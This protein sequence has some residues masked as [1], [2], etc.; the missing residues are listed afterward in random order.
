M[1]NDPSYTDQ[2]IFEGKVVIKDL[3]CGYWS[4]NTP[5]PNPYYINF[6]KELWKRHPNLIIVGDTWGSDIL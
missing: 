2:E 3:N 1:N 4:I 5:Y 6:V